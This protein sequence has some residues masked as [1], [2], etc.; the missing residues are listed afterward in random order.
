MKI[1][2]IGC[3]HSSER[4]LQQVL[5]HADAEVVGI[6]TRSASVQNS[7][8]VSLQPL[9][10][11]HDIPCLL[12]DQCAE[13]D[14]LQWVAA[15]APDV[16]YCFGWSQLLPAALLTLPRLGAI[17]FHPAALPH[18]RGRH[19]IIWTLAL[20]L[21]RTA[22]SF[23]FMTA[24]ADAGDLISQAPV[25]ITDE[26]DAA[27]LYARIM[28]VAVEQVDTFTGQL[29]RGEYPRIPQDAAGANHWRKR[30]R[31]DGRI[32]WR[33]PARG[34]HNLVRA[35]AR[36]YPGA[37][38]VVAGA[39]IT[40][41]K[42]RPLDRAPANLEPGK[43]LDVDAGVITVKCGEGAVQLL[44]HDFTTLPEAGSYL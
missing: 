29:A 19:P 38:C 27:S 23:F 7:D 35:L 26:D 15:H 33:M 31:N 34:I 10:E 11:R 14:V 18:N 8:F 37:H 4:L 25:A 28:D 1:L 21:E 36:P 40:V 24:A 22:S 41:W 5:G 2:F 32:D 20:G 16:I 12:Q 39:E 6:V 13:K 43:V 3:V 44:E 30:G 9:A 42:T 17:G